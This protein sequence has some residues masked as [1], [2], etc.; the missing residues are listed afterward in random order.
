MNKQSFALLFTGLLSVAIGI[1][2]QAQTLT[3]ITPKFISSEQA[4]Q[5]KLESDGKPFIPAGLGRSVKPNEGGVRGIP[6][7]I[8]N[9]IPMLSRKYPWSAIGR[10]QG[11]ETNGQSYHCTGSLIAD[12]LVLTNAHCVIN[13]SKKFTHIYP[14]M[15][16]AGQPER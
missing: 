4:G 6:T 3:S 15:D 7:G 16:K 13:R 2:A 12:N 10:V 8:D 11:T 14:Q 1:S 5:L 9:R